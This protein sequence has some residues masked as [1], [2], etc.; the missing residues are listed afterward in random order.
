M[1]QYNLALERLD[2]IFDV[3]PNSV[4]WNEHQ[5]LVADIVAF[6]D[7]LNFGIAPADFMKTKGIE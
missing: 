5:K 2:V 7:A 3:A 1:R 4:E 6:E